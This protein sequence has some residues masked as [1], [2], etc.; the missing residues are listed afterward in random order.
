MRSNALREKLFFVLVFSLVA[1][2]GLPNMSWSAIGNVKAYG[3]SQH[4]IK[5]SQQSSSKPK[6]S[7]SNQSMQAEITERQIE[8]R[9]NPKSPEAHVRLAE[10]YRTYSRYYDSVES[11]KHAIRIRP[12]YVEAYLGLAEVYNMLTIFGDKKQP[13]TEFAATT[14]KQVI[15]IKPDS[16][17]AHLG[18][19]KTYIL[20]DRED[21][22]IEE[23][24]IAIRIRPNYADAFMEIGHTYMSAAREEK[25]KGANQ[26][27][28]IRIYGEDIQIAI[29]AFKQ[30]AS[31]A[32]NNEL[33]Y[34]NLG[35]AYA[36]ISRYDEAINAYM[37]VIQMTPYGKWGE[38]YFA[39]CEVY[40]QSDRLSEGMKTF[41]QMIQ[42]KPDGSWGYYSLGMM[43]LYS[44][45]KGSAL[46]QYTIMKSLK[47]G[48]LADSLFKEIYK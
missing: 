5:I 44:G 29:N 6:Q 2:T 4:L 7:S 23:F 28:I 14:Y 15:R 47:S 35:R 45:D 41:K 27:E 12:D 36:L 1:I 31:I 19:G 37:Q 42:S 39:L 33:A 18:L 11:Y 9:K 48:D 46:E 3:T 40:R 22:A 8:I 10:T 30:V 38:A 32:P 25:W 24:R 20:L 13:F 21:E 17:E 16:A 43:Y 34:L 26:Q